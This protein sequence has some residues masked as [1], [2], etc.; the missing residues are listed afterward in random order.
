MPDDGNAR[1]LLP[2]GGIDP[3]RRAADGGRVNFIPPLPPDPDADP[4]P[5]LDPECAEIADLGA[6]GA[7]IS[8]SIPSPDP[9]LPLALAPLAS[10]VPLCLPADPVAEAR[11]ASARYFSNMSAD[12]PAPDSAELAD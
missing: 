5:M 12:I 11:P 9:P 3:L 2:A 8:T 7:T 4:D 6:G 10:L 1:P